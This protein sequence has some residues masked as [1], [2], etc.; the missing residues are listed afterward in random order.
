MCCWDFLREWSCTSLLY[1]STDF[2]DNFVQFF[3][4]FDTIF[5]KVTSSFPF[6]EQF[7]G[8]LFL[9]CR[10]LACCNVCN[11]F[12]I[13]FMPSLYNNHYV[14]LLLILFILF[15]VLQLNLL[16]FT[17]HIWDV[18]LLWTKGNVEKNC[19]CVTVLWTIIM[20]HKGTSSSYRSVDCIGL[21]SCLV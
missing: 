9:V 17:S 13:I 19:L 10:R 6:Y 4:I 7:S 1:F 8:A 14:C 15:T 12:W 2:L 5:P 3:H 16:T 21:W 18:M 11:Y 20:V